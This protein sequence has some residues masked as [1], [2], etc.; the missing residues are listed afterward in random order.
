MNPILQF[1][2]CYEV[3]L[4]KTFA[5]VAGQAIAATHILHCLLCSGYALHS[6]FR[7]E[8]QLHICLSATGEQ[9]GY[10]PT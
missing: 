1:V 8:V 7:L 2:A 10:A 9:F 6:C 5:Q 4:N 3:M